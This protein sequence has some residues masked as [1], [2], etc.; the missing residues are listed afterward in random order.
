MPPI[1]LESE[2]ICFDASTLM[3][4]TIANNGKYVISKNFHTMGG[5][6]KEVCHWDFLVSFSFG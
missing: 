4:L 3:I 5:I 6:C 2:S 1:L